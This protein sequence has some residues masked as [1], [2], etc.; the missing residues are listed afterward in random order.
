MHFSL[1][2]YRQIL[3]RAQCLHSDGFVVTV[4]TG[5][6]VRGDE[7]FSDDSVSTFITSVA[8]VAMVAVCVYV[9]RQDVCSNNQVNCSAGQC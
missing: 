3:D 8:A 5:G 9:V 7:D 4:T 1:A 6:A 2:W